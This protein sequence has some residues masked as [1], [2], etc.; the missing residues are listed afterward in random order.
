MNPDIALLLDLVRIYSP[1]THEQEASA[2]LVEAM[3]T[4]G[5]DAAFVDGAGNAVGIWGSGPREIVLLGH[6]DTVPG[7]IAVRREGDILYG[8][9]AVDAKGPL[10]CF[11]AAVSRLP[12]RRTCRLVVIGAVE[13]EAAT[14]KGARHV[15][16]QYHPA[17]CI[18]GEPSQWSCVTLGYKGRLLMDYALR[19]EV[20]HSA[21]QLPSAPEVAVAFWQ[22]LVQ[23]AAAFNQDRGIFDTLDPSLRSINSS[24]DGMYDMVTQRI[25]LRVPLGYDIERLKRQLTESAGE[26]TL[27][28][29]GQ[30]LAYKSDKRNMLVKAFLKAIRAHDGQPR[31]KV[32]TGTS[33]MNVLAPHWHCPFVAYGPGDSAFDHTP[34]EQISLQEYEKAIDVLEQTL[35]ILVESLH[36]SV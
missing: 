12:K 3:R 23:R 2:F 17:C 28:F 34:Q 30:E 6:I 14:S 36:D 9:G 22:D 15:I 10:A 29:F 31:F 16:E 20:S 27:R 4:R 25:G 5:F 32:K 35:C 13:E 24:D 19:R 26:A 1:S 18:I 21:G 8:R 7:E 11:V 33:D